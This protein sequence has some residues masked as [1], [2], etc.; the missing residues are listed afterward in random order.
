MENMR[1]T[2]GS[3]IEVVLGAFAHMDACP[4]LNTIQDVY[5][6]ESITVA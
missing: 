1:E 4:L 5:L 2:S 6:D 3:I